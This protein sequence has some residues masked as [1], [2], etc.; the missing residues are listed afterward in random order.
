MQKIF[1]LRRRGGVRAATCPK[2]IYDR[3]KRALAEFRH[4]DQPTVRSDERVDPFDFVLVARLQLLSR[5]PPTRAVGKARYTKIKITIFDDLLGRRKKKVC[6]SLRS[7]R[8][9]ISTAI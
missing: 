3:Q 7:R 4:R 9:I 8:E 1:T 5:C 2:R 6:L